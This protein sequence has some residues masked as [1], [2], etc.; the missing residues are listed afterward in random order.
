MQNERRDPVID[1]AAEVASL[2]ELFNAK[3]TELKQEGTTTKY[4]S[5]SL[6]SDTPTIT[7]LTLQISSIHKRA[8]LWKADFANERVSTVH[9][10]RK[11]QDDRQFAIQESELKNKQLTEK[12]TNLAKAATEERE[13]KISK[14]TEALSLAEASLQERDAELRDL[15]EE[16]NKSVV[17]SSTAH[18]SAIEIEKQLMASERRRTE[19]EAEVENVKYKLQTIE[20]SEGEL[21]DRE[22]RMKKRI[23]LYETKEFEYKENISELNGHLKAKEVALENI[24]ESFEKLTGMVFGSFEEV[25]A[26]MKEKL[27]DKEKGLQNQTLENR[28]LELQVTDLEH[29]LNETTAALMDNKAALSRIDNSFKDTQ[30]SHSELEK[31]LEDRDGRLSDC[32]TFLRELRSEFGND[33]PTEDLDNDTL[34]NVSMFGFR[35]W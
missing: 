19:L 10:L 17:S 5:I 28:R 8:L 33:T 2:R 6:T 16:V 23:A 9:E 24:Q 4:D 14:L 25:E 31:L 11:A 35:Y 20:Q 7:E 32:M 18:K 12:F 1:L 27:V 15:R 34:I 3:G 21:N 30:S 29:Q 13:R 26:N 22:T